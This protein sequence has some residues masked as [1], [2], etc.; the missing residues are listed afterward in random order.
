MRFDTHSIAVDGTQLGEWDWFSQRFNHHLLA[1]INGINKW[2]QPWAYHLTL[3]IIFLKIQ[4]HMQFSWPISLFK[5]PP[6]FS[7]PPHIAFKQTTFYSVHFSL[8]PIQLSTCFFNWR[9]VFSLFFLLPNLLYCL[10]CWFCNTFYP[11]L[12][13][14]TLDPLLS[15]VLQ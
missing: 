8:C 9:T 4:N 15:N 12:S 3:N 14:I 10:G 11:L 1:R 13:Y 2:M 6:S 5:H 7:P